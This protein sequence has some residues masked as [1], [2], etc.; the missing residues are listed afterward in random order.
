[1]YLSFSIADFENPSISFFNP[2]P[3]RVLNFTFPSSKTPYYLGRKIEHTTGIK[4][5][6]SLITN[7]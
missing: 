7:I 3:I 6:G 2:I 4:V 5:S 1:M